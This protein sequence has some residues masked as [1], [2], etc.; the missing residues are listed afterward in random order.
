MP[1]AAMK[2]STTMKASAHARLSASGHSSYGAAMIKAAECAGMS[3][4]GVVRRSWSVLR[5]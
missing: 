4:H 3:S 2:A 5:N 1:S